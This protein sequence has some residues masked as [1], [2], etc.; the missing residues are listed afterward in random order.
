[1]SSR[2]EDPVLRGARREATVAAV[3]YVAALVYTILYCSLRG[4]RRSPE[5][6]TFILGFPDWVFWG[7][8]VPWGACF[9]LSFWFAYGFMKDADLGVDRDREED[10]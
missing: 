4:Y 1:M 3:I 8:I 9:V 6:L 5:S 7:V 2:R 10:A